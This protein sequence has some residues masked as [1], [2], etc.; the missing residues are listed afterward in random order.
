MN[1]I[2]RLSKIDSSLFCLFTLTLLFTLFTEP[3]IQK[4][5]AEAI[6]SWQDQAGRI[7]YGS[8]PPANSINKQKISNNTFSK[9]S[10]KKLLKGYGIENSLIG[11]KKVTD[12]KSSSQASQENTN[13]RRARLNNYDFNNLPQAQIAPKKYKKVESFKNSK[14]HNLKQEKNSYKQ[15]NYRIIKPKNISSKLNNSKKSLS[16]SNLKSPI[17]FKQEA[18][19]TI[20]KTFNIKEISNT[21][22]DPQEILP[23]QEFSSSLDNFNNVASLKEKSIVNENS[24]LNEESRL[25]KSGR[26]KPSLKLVNNT[27]YEISLFEPNLLLDAHQQIVAISTMVRNNSVNKISVNAYF[28][29][30]DDN[31]K[32]IYLKASGPEEISPQTLGYY[33]LD[34]ENLPLQKS[35]RNEI[36]LVIKPK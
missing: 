16:P 23:G 27:N 22:N 17:K 9:Y 10:S 13:S 5:L 1:F 14:I 35:S 12:L 34:R 28:Q 6:Y 2:L 7:H 32:P 3:F 20:N 33:E 36:L 31:N 4:S 30:F 21:K 11:G 19:K 8:K 18:P 24:S 25:P 26:N 15:D 29:T